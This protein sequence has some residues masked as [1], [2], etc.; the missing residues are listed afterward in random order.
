MFLTSVGLENRKRK[1][2]TYVRKERG[3]ESS[4]RRFLYVMRSILRGALGTSST[5]SVVTIS[6]L[7]STSNSRPETIGR[8][9]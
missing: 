6:T 2:E 9:H 3:R 5:I 7:N 4:I 8:D 1:E